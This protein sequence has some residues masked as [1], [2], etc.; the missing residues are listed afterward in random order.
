MTDKK[1]RKYGFIETSDKTKFY[2]GDLT[3]NEYRIQDISIGLARETRFS[4]HYIR[5][6]PFYSVAE[7]S[8]HMARWCLVNE[9]QKYARAALMHDASEA[10][11]KDLT[12]PL[13]CTQPAYKPME[14]VVSAAIA[15]TFGVK[16]MDSPFIKKLDE[17]MLNT[18][19]E[20]IMAPTDNIWNTEHVGKLMGV[21]IRGWLPQKAD[22]EFLKMFAM[23]GDL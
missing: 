23:L 10:Y 2:F 19:R 14:K 20:Q 1:S 21:K 11:L 16:H 4:G 6:I 7:H 3:N 5:T 17:Q 22:V 12:R 18:E 9:K 13:K 15:K 8:V